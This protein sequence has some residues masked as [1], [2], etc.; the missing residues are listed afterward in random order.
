MKHVALLL[1]ALSAC[2]TA[3]AQPNKGNPKE[4]TTWDICVVAP[5]EPVILPSDTPPHTPP[6]E[7]PQ[8]LRYGTLPVPLY[9]AGEGP[10]P[11]L[12]ARSSA[13]Q[14][15]AWLGF[16][17]LRYDPAAIPDETQ[18]AILVFVGQP[19]DILLGQAF[20]MRSEKGWVCGAGVFYTASDVHR[21]VT[22]EVG[23]CLG[24]AH[25]RDTETSVMH[26][27]VTEGPYALTAADRF[28]LRDL[29]SVK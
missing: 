28:A 7:A 5:W 4:R 10:F 11:E 12:L 23:H 26:P 9:S 25:D 15:N 27:H 8:K 18:N 22:H 20:P 19:S 16:E 24:L 1:I 14:W 13:L 2:A 29:Y 6:C 3:H 21:T 17:F